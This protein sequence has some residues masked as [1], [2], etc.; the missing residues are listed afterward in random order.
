MG[1]TV[2][3]LGCSGSYPA[4]GEACSGYLVQTPSTNVV[5][6]LGPGCMA[7]LQRHIEL[8][9]LDAVVLSHSHP[10]HWVDL[11]GLRTALR[12]RFGIEALPVYGT[13]E[14]YELASSLTSA[15]DPTFDWH[16]TVD[17]SEFA[18]DSLR[19]RTSATEHY[20]ETLAVRIDDDVS[21]NS[22]GYSADT[23]PGW[24]LRELGDGIDLALCESTY[25]TDEEAEGVLHLSAAQ[26]GAMAK[27]A[28]VQRLVLTHLFPDTD[29][30]AHRSAGSAAFGRSA[31]V[32]RTHERYEL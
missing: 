18:V 12:Y 7:N 3:I 26:A 32:A 15:L 10:D 6:D 31:D 21:G 27:A 29:V 14:T 8:P 11:T 2:T 9:A 24:T 19:F 4:E 16:E 22:I 17:G 20:V 23:G 28:G 13:R 30:E 1:L 25:P 5:V